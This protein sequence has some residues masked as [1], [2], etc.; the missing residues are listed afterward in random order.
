V[1]RIPAENR[2]VAER[3]QQLGHKIVVPN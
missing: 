3:V 2:R 1:F